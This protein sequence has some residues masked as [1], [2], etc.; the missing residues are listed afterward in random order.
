MKL[1]EKPKK[2]KTGQYVTGEDVLSE[3]AAEHRIVADL[4]AYRESSKL[5]STYVDALPNEVSRR[6]GRVHTTF[7]QT[8]AATGRLAS[9]NPNLQNIPIRTEQGRAIRKA[10]VAGGPDMVF[11]SAD[12]SQIELRVMASLSAD[13]AMMEA[14]HKGEDIHQSTAARVYAVLPEDVTADM[15]RTAKMVNFGI[16]YGISA[17]GLSQ[18]L[19][20]PRPE[21]ARLID[22]YFIQYPGVKAYMDRTIEMAKDK[23]YVETITGRR[24]YLR[25]IRSANA[26]T[27]KAAERVAINAPIQGTAADM[28]KLAMVHMH[29][30]LRE[31][32]LKCRMI[33]QVHDELLFE[34]PARELSAAKDIVSDVMRNALKLSVPVVVEM[35]S[36]KSWFEA[37]A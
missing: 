11:L 4:L 8:G 27:R 21:G 17:F 30:R 20:I 5:K 19:G 2:T 15:R 24:R 13:P 12:Y 36:G 7:H 9:N 22:E 1:I 35:G 3:L 25:D 37:H 14:F 18:R 26:M 16:I 34:L 10:F 31:A 33:L 28:I 32:K 23:G 29:A 6:T